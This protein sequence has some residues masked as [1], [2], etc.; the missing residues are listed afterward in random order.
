MGLL[1]A[2][3]SLLCPGRHYG[4][5]GKTRQGVAVRVHSW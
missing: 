5:P 4:V 1:N 2:I 3:L